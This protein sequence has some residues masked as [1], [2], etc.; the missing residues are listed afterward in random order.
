MYIYTQVQ[1]VLL[2]VF[3]QQELGILPFLSFPMV[4]ELREKKKTL[5]ISGLSVNPFWE[6]FQ[7]SCFIPVTFSIS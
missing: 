5:I 7:W 4:S 2:T 3:Q 1:C 6:I